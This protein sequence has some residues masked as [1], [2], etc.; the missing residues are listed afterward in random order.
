MGYVR[1][2]SSSINV[3]F[4]RRCL[5]RNFDILPGNFAAPAKCLTIASSEAIFRWR[6]KLPAV[7]GV[8]PTS[9]TM[10]TILTSAFT[11]LLGLVLGHRLAI[12]RDKRKEFNDAAAPIRGWFLGAKDS[13]NPY[14]RWP[15]EQELDRFLHYLWPWQRTTFQKRL[16]SY[17][18]LHQARQVQ[19]AAGQGRAHEVDGCA[20]ICARGLT[21]R[22]RGCRVAAPL[23]SSVRLY[24][25]HP[26]GIC[27]SNGTQ[28][29][30]RPKLDA[31]HAELVR[32][33][34]YST[35]VQKRITAPAHLRNKAGHGH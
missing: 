25:C 15:S 31:M 1:N 27:G 32:A 34:V 2:A 12:S 16:A 19:D 22:S 9:N 11:F 29:S 13:P 23:N 24:P 28:L 35:L 6:Y 18:A 7:A 10:A 8:R 20:R 14:T 4:G 17:K 3:E 5:S 26:R 33:G 30:A 21:T